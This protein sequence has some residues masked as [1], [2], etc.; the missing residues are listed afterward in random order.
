MVEY[1]SGDHIIHRLVNSNNS[2]S[3]DLN[4]EL[5]K[6][7]ALPKPKLSIRKDSDGVIIKI[8]KSPAHPVKIFTKRG[9]EDNFTF[10]A[11]VS[12][13]Q[14]ADTRPNAFNAPELREYMAYYV[15]EEVQVGPA[16]DVV[17]IIKK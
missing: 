13:N 3:S 8:E 9:S 15:S 2:S 11:Q 4:E 16:S 14:Y 17:L 12:E 10:L 6:P 5:L 1:I 7:E